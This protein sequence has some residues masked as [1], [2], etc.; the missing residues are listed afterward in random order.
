MTKEEVLQMTPSNADYSRYAPVLSAMDQF[1]KHRSIEFAKWIMQNCRQDYMDVE[2][3]EWYYSP[4]DKLLDERM[5]SDQI[6]NEFLKQY[7]Q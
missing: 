6:F 3:D 2:N 1:A 4:E 7:N 5:T